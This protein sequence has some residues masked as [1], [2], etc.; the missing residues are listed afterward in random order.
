MTCTTRAIQTVNEI[1]DVS[2]CLSAKY[3][4]TCFRENTQVKIQ[5][6]YKAA[7]HLCLW[8]E[9]AKRNILNL[10]VYEKT[11]SK[12]NTLGKRRK[13]KLKNSR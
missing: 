10:S 5:S 4:I 6:R 11:K 12:I 9:I 13:L 8:T 3:Y 1:S 2:Q 7:L